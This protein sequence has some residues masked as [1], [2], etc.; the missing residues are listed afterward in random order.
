L[1]DVVMTARY[2]ALEPWW[3]RYHHRRRGR[4]TDC[5]ERMGVA[6]LAERSLGTVCRA[7][8]SVCCWPGR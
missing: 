5:L 2:A 3:H 8:S 6:W 4:A 7:S 1:L